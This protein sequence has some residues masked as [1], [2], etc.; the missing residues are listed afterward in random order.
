LL[1]EYELS[2]KNR[3]LKKQSVDASSREKS[4]DRCGSS[5]SLE[6]KYKKTK[7]QPMLL[8]QTMMNSATPGLKEQA[9]SFL[10]K[11]SIEEARPDVGSRPANNGSVPLSQ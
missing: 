8:K 11:N 9:V 2:L 3:I 5:H 4:V 7:S 10:N 1:K 6:H